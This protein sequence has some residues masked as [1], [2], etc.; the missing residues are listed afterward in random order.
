MATLGGGAAAVGTLG[1]SIPAQA[2]L[3]VQVECRR[4]AGRRSRVAKVVRE[5]AANP[6][7]DAPTARSLSNPKS[8]NRGG[9]TSARTSG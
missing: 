3:L 4:S 7:L 6:G 8:R 1:A 5:N 2:A 9:K